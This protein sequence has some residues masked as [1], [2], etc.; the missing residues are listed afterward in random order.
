M[1]T[2]IG[3]YL[4]HFGNREQPIYEE[5]KVDTTRDRTAQTEFE[6]ETKGEQFDF[7][8][9]KDEADGSMKF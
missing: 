8:E 5:D 3:W 9:G 7:N 6:P 2:I 1:K 4:D